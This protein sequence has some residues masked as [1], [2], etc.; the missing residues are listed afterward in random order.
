MEPEKLK[1]EQY[2][3]SIAT[4]QEDG[5]R[6][7]VFAKKVKGKFYNYRQLFGYFLLVFL[8]VA[9]FI[10]INGQPLLLF[11][12]LERKF[13]IFGVIFWP[14]DSFLFYLM[15]LSLIIFIVLFTV[16]FGR[17]F[18]GWACPQT[19][20]LELI[21]RRIEWLIDGN[22]AKQK[23]L[24]RQGW[25]F[26]KLF[27]RLL[28]HGIFWGISF[29]IANTLLALIIGADEVLKIASE[30]ISEHQG[31]F[32]AMVVFTSAFYF[33]YAWFREQVCTIM[34][35]YGRLQGVLTDNDTITVSYDYFRG[36][37]RGI[38]KKTEPEKAAK[39]GDCVDCGECIRVCPTGIDIR[40]GVQLECVN[41]TACMD[42][43]N[44]VMDKVKKPRGLIR[45]AS[46]NGLKTGKSFKFTPRN[47]AYSVVLLGIIIFFVTLLATRSDTETTI[48]RAR[49]LTYQ[50][51]PDDQISN[52]YNISI[53]N[54]THDKI[55]PDIKLLSHKG[56]IEIRGSNLELE[57]G[58]S[59]E[60]AMIVYL[61]EDDLKKK[62]TMLKFG[63]YKNGELLEEIETNFLGPDK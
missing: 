9:P 35:P 59:A 41:C 20:F 32:I 60:A 63:V 40:N 49:G 30:P 18:C 1:G 45:Y 48:L 42:A 2:R 4:I 12:V 57:S 6:A 19:I 52:V 62:K 5:N 33:I 13:V 43:C 7:W 54:K 25:T 56:K 47:I 10:K 16:I 38:A 50:E 31:S 39:L 58:K 11:N 53:V 28:K 51:Q 15:M 27:K 55:K 8:F 36:E 34:C 46:E 24:R 29:L 26:T 22:P 21:F 61:D 17:L 3:D 23:K 14:Q 37:P 44:N